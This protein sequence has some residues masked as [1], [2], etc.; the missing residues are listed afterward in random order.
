MSAKSAGREATEEAILGAATAEFIEKGFHGA[1]MEHIAKRAGVNKAL[2]YRY[3]RDR[4]RL[5]DAVLQRQIAQREAILAGIPDRLGDALE[6]WYTET[7]RSGRDLVRLLQREAL[8]QAVSGEI[9]EQQRRRDYYRAQITVL[10]SW[11]ADGRVTDDL[12]ARH[13][14]LALLALVAFPLGFPQLTRLVTGKR[15]Q[16]PSFVREWNELLNGL[17]DHLAGDGPRQE[18]SG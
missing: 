11:Q 2:V 6:V 17:A 16:D 18:P 4:A 1:R 9:V 10:E 12:D 8:D 3:F 14:F 13:L 7:V 15:P 5:A